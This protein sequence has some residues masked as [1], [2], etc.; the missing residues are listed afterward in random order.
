MALDTTTLLFVLAG[1]SLISGAFL[2]FLRHSQ[3]ETA[4]TGNMAS[5]MLC[6]FAGFGMIALRAELPVTL[7]FTVANILICAGYLLSLRGYCRFRGIQFPDVYV[8]APLVAY[9]LEFSYFLY[10]DNIYWIRLFFYLATYAAITI[11]LVSLILRDY[12]ATGHRSYLVA[13]AFAGFMASVFVATS[14]LTVGYTGAADILSISA[15]NTLVSAGQIVF[16]VGWTLSYA[17]IVTET[18][19]YYDSLTGLPNR[20]RLHEIL[21]KTIRNADGARAPFPLFLLDLDRFKEVNDTLGHHVGD[22][23]LKSVSERIRK[24]AESRRGAAARLGGDEFAVV[25]PD[26]GLG[27]AKIVAETMTQALRH[28]FSIGDLHVAV[29]ASVGI[30]V[31]PTDGQDSSSLLR[32]ADIAMYMAKR[33]QIR[34]SHYDIGADTYSMKRLALLADLGDVLR[35]GPVGDE[36]G[37]LVLHFQPVVRLRDG[38]MTGMEALV[39]WQHPRHGLMLPGDW[40]PMAEMSDLIDDLTIWVLDAAVRQARRWREQ[41]CDWCMKINVSARNLVDSVFSSQLRWTLDHQNLTPDAIELEITETAM[42]ADPDRALATLRQVADLGVKIAIDDFGIGYSSFWTL[43]RFPG[44][45][46]VKIDQSFVG[47]MADNTADA[48]V[49]KSLISLAHDLG[50]RS[51]AEGVE[52]EK[53]FLLLRDIGCLE[54]QGFFIAKPMPAE[55]LFSWSN[56]ALSAI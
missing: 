48:A 31:Y 40:L 4:G 25:V 17:L 47:R 9:T 39:R 16:V 51:I 6:F 24:V 28:P 26:A 43:R 14:I 52:D 29:G 10:V 41:G 27:E 56:V 22:M 32:C 23:L 15:I 35:G 34:F 45:A 18:I 44:V 42:M 53:T 46:S 37:N 1:V 7:S 8:V 11:V 55:A 36:H 19:G 21:S 49:V 13:A 54:A 30:A 38:T 50:I 2:V 5:S 33:S 12:R 20:R 3:P